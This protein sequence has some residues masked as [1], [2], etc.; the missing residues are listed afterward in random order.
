[1]ANNP[2]DVDFVQVASTFDAVEKA[3]ALASSAVEA[4]LAACAQLEG[5][6]TSV[7]WWD[8]AVQRDREWR[9]T[10]KTTAALADRLTEHIVHEHT[11]D[12]PEVVV[13]PLVGGH[14]EYLQWL[15]DETRQR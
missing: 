9:L 3:E 13:T 10:F 2:V 11:Y 12:V 5:P 1:M 7:Y 6:L 8:G 4:R 14:Q 15:R